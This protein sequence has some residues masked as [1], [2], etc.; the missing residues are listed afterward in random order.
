MGALTPVSHSSLLLPCS[1]P[2][3]SAMATA[4]LV[5]EADGAANP[6]AGESGKGVS[7]GTRERES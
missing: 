2:Q 5:S 6:Y 1:I 4:L 7:R 3:Y